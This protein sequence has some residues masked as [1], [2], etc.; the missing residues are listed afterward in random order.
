MDKKISIILP[1]RNEARSLDTLLPQILK[2]DDIDEVIV[3]ND[4]STDD[5]VAICQKYHVKM[6]NHIYQ[7]GNG[8]AIKSGAREASGDI[9]VFMDADGQHQAHEIPKLLQ[10]MEQGFDM[11]VGSRSA[12]SQASIG[13]LCANSFYNWFA[14]LM[15]GQKVADLT[16]GLRAVR[17]KHFKKFLYLLPN[18]FS[19]P[20]TITIAF[21]R[22]GYHVGYIPIKAQ[23]RLGKSHLKPFKD[24]LRFLLILFKIGTLY[25]PLKVFL[26]ISMLS[27]ITGFCYYLYTYI[28]VHRFTNMSALLF[29]T[30]IIIFLI[31]LV[32]EQ[33]TL[34][35]Y[36]QERE[37]KS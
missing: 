9:L 2:I 11:I 18:G 26:P 4:A 23:K 14:T 16:S 32:A 27:F 22:S 20:A 7:K 17:T 19:Y 5:T 12:A 6:V 34:L 28:T 25:S 37:D 35:T 31:G 13:R 8:A 33:I 21:F 24:G 1:A 29:T 30:A 10:K 15:V 3:V 36:S